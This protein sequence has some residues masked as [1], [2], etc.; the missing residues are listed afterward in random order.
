[1]TYDR[2]RFYCAVNNVSGIVYN[3][4][5]FSY[6]S[7]AIETPCVSKVYFRNDSSAFQINTVDMIQLGASPIFVL[8]D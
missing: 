2:G 6:S 5:I 7:Y 8:N 4:Y 1:M 3:A